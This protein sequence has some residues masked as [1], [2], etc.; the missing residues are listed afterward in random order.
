MNQ[1]DE[2]S[3]K[4]KE[5]LAKRVGTLCSNPRCSVPTYGPNVDPGKST[6]KG[7][8]AHITAASPGGPRYDPNMT[9]EERSSVDN[10][11][12]LCENCAK[13]IDTDVNRYTIDFIRDWKFKAED[14]AQKA[15]ENPRIVNFGPDFADTILFITRQLEVPALDRS[16]LGPGQW[17]TRT[18]T[19]RPI[20]SERQVINIRAPLLLKTRED[21]DSG[22]IPP[23]ACI[24]YLTCQNQGTGVDQYIKIDIEF[25]KSA[26][27]S[28]DIDSPDQLQLINGGKASSTFASFKI[29]DL[30]PGEYQRV[31]IIAQSNTSFKA[32]LWSQNS[33]ESQAVFIYDVI[34]GAPEK[35]PQNK[36]P[37]WARPKK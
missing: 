31:K 3:P 28:V 13:L 22:L 33:G 8:A 25:E 16:G 26:I 30:L 24:L 2:F 4:T 9:E 35:V 6:N 20:H 1:R 29:R 12:W 15:L 36:L 7:V 23:G 5:I 34:F 37:H 32:K 10:G 27:I 17:K 18:I 14:R 19:F 11:I 21:F